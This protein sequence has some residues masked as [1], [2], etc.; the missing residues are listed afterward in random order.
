M[1]SGVVHP[2]HGHIRKDGS[3][4]TKGGNPATPH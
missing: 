2:K 1:A 3:T 4:A